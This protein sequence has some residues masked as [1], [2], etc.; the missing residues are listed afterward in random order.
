MKTSC[1]LQSSFIGSY[2]LI[3]C[4][5]PDFKYIDSDGVSEGEFAVVEELELGRMKGKSVI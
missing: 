1:L 2:A 4:R 3:P 5:S